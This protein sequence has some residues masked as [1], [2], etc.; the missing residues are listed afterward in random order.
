M[1]IKIQLGFY[2]TIL[3]HARLWQNKLIIYFGEVIASPT[4]VGLCRGEL[5]IKLGC[6]WHKPILRST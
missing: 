6:K 3:N 4:K 2:P 1:Q 5:I